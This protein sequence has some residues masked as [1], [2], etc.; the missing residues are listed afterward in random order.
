MGIPEKEVPLL[1]TVKESVKEMSN[2][3]VNRGPSWGWLT[4]HL[5]AEDSGDVVRRKGEGRVV[6][7]ATKRSP[8]ERRGVKSR[9]YFKLYEGGDRLKGAEA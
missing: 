8:G 7:G 2:S 4:P 9:N 3:A 6:C 5:K 1:A